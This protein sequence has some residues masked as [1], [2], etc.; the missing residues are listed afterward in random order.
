MVKSCLRKCIICCRW[1]HQ[2]PVQLMGTLP[3]AR[4][5]PC[6]PFIRAGVDYAGPIQVRSGRGRGQKSVK[7]YIALFIC[8]ATKAVHLELVSDGSAETFLAALRRFVARRGICSEMYSD[9]GT[10]FV[11]ANRE[12]RTLLR[13]ALLDGRDLLATIAAEGIEWKFN[14]PAAPH[15]GG[16]WEAAVKSVKHHLRRQIGE[17]KLTF[18]ELSTLL[19]GIEACLNSRPL[20]PLSDDPEDLQALTPGHF[21]IGGPVIAIPEPSLEEVPMSRLSRWQLV[22]Q[23]Q[24][25]FWRRWSKEY[26]NTL[27]TRDKW[28]Q[29]QPAIQKGTLCLLK[30][31]LL[32]PTRWPLARITSVHP[33]SDGLTRVVTVRTAK[34]EVKR[35]INKVIP[36]PIPAEK[37]LDT[38]TRPVNGAN[39]KILYCIYLP[40]L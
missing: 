17:Q 21:L 37:S 16:L 2:P 34:T 18:E 9:C 24:Q 29:V 30:N 12:L 22:Q 20:E 35:P 19:A 13:A 32:P 33:G 40:F 15:F 31:E 8:L 1:R 26:L 4:V 3:R 6:R 10:N 38:A 39:L 23:I 5:I 14:P 28:C 36:L 25:H 11:G 27:Q 7:G